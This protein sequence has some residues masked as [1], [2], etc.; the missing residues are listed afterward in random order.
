[1]SSDPSREADFGLLFALAF[2]C[3]L[4]HLHGELEHAGFTGGRSAFGPVLRALRAG[5]STLVGLAR[6]LGVTKQAVARV[7]EDMRSDGLVDQ[8]SDPADGRARLLSL[9]ARGRTM[10][11]TAIGIGARFESALAS[12]LGDDRVRELRADLEH[13]VG[14]A[15]AAGELAARRVRSI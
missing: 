7:I 12:E 5:D 11:E 8:R 3:Y 9:T 13:V 14:R 6:D 2:R 1:M 10:V 15:G 4:D